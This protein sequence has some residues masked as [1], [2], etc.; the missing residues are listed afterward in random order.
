M[1]MS[2]DDAR[3]RLNSLG[4]ERLHPK[5]ITGASEEMMASVRLE[6]AA[7]EADAPAGVAEP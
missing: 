4:G 7:G 3:T 2:F 5:Y 1:L 6:H